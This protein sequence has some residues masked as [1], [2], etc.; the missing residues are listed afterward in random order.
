MFPKSFV[1]AGIVSPGYDK[2]SIATGSATFSQV[3][4]HHC[5]VKVRLS[6]SSMRPCGLDFWDH[7]VKTPPYTIKIILPSNAFE[8][9]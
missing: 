9:R 5:H 6:E 8:A 2:K 3:K 1:L 7:S 4:D